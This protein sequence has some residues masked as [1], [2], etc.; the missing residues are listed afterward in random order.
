MVMK[1]ASL[2][3]AGAMDKS[4]SVWSL[5]LGQKNIAIATSRTGCFSSYPRLA[6]IST[7]TLK[8]V[9]LG[10]LCFWPDTKFDPDWMKKKTDV[11]NF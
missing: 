9:A 1:A 5:K 10:Q 7:Q 8:T 4:W 6:R 2:V 11:K 3:W